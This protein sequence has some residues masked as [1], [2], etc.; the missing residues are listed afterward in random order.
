MYRDKILS[1][2]PGISCE[3]IQFIDVFI[4]EWNTSDRNA[5][6]MNINITTR[7]YRIAQDLVGS[8]WI[9]ETKR[10]IIIALW[11][12]LVDIIKSF[13]YLVIAFESLGAQGSGKCTNLIC[14]E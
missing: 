10:E 6:S 11:V 1:R 2:I 12:E 7:F 5:A 14:L 13:G 4:S 9:I 8:I 3:N